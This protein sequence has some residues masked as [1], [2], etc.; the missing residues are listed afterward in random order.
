MEVVSFALFQGYVLLRFGLE[1]SRIR[2]DQLSITLIGNPRLTP[3][4]RQVA[5]LRQSLN[6]REYCAFGRSVPSFQMTLECR[7]SGLIYCNATITPSV[8]HLHGIIEGSDRTDQAQEG[9][10]NHQIV[11]PYIALQEKVRTRHNISGKDDRRL[12]KFPCWGLTIF[13]SMIYCTA[14]YK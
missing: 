13:Y 12:K 5:R 6:I 4:D 7:F 3:L 2:I 11:F 10:D 1:I 9:V 14:T 8:S